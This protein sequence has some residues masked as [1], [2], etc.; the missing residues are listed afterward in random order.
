MAWLG[1]TK[2]GQRAKGARSGARRRAREH[3]AAG[4]VRPPTL[5]EVYAA[6][7]GLVFCAV[8][9]LPVPREQASIEHAQPLAK[10]GAHDAT[11]ASG[12][13]HRKCNSRK[14]GRVG[15]RRKGLKRGKPLGRKPRVIPPEAW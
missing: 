1:T 5:D 10:G 14:A 2:A 8:C 12:I 4:A 13:S 15:P 3:A 7:G 9:R 11:N 6:A